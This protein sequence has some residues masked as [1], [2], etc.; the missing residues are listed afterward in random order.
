MPPVLY[1]ALLIGL[2]ALS[3]AAAPPALVVPDPDPVVVG[4]FVEH[5]RDNI[6][7]GSYPDGRPLE[8]ETPAERAK[9]ILPQKLAE[10]VWL[11]G[12][13]SGQIEGCS[14]DWQKVSFEPLMAKL[15]ARG[16]LAPKQLG[17][18]AL[19]HDSAREQGNKGYEENCTP[20]YKRALMATVKAL[21][22]VRL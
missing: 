6:T 12:V 16:D 18:A 19:L 5:M 15:R 8:I 21:E 11:R 22:G 7:L 4:R 14:G 20:D 9:P 10:Q 17:F 3:I 13:V 1:S 2:A